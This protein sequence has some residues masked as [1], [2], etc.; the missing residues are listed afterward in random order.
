MSLSVTHSRL[1]ASRT[2]IFNIFSYSL[3]TT[4]YKSL[5]FYQVMGP[6]L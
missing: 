3:Q 5:S 6:G 4:E 2:V 1:Q